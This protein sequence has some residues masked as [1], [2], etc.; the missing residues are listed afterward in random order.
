V[1]CVLLWRELFVFIVCCV[2][3]RGGGFLSLY[4]HGTG[5]RVRSMYQLLKL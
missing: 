5:R 4:E 2:Y 3:K 1:P